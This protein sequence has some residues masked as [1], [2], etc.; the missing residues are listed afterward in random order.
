MLPI[1]TDFLVSILFMPNYFVPTLLFVALPFY[2]LFSTLDS[3]KAT[4]KQVCTS[5]RIFTEG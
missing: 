5:G 3:F 1:G 2:L 4:W